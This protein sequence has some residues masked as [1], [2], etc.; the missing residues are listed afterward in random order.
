MEYNEAELELELE[1]VTD[2][3][4][5]PSTATCSVIMESNEDEVVTDL[6]DTATCSASASTSTCSTVF[7]ESECVVCGSE[8]IACVGN[9]RL[10]TVRGGLSSLKAASDRRRD[11]VLSNYLQSKPAVVK[12]HAC[13]RLRYNIDRPCPVLKRKLSVEA[14]DCTGGAVKMLHSTAE[15][16]DWKTDCFLC[17]KN[18]V[19]DVKHFPKTKHAVRVAETKKLFQSLRTICDKRQDKWGLTWLGGWIRAVMVLRLKLDTI[20]NA[21]GTSLQLSAYAR[22]VKRSAT[23]RTTS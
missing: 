15:T 14:D 10:I 1:L 19:P 21:I 4:D 9:T 20:K 13:C 18:A 17:C 8:T 12:V 5:A 11:T 22:Y 3:Q 6:Q 7:G 16:W 23:G 2:I